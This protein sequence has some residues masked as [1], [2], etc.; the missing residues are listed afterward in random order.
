MRIGTGGFK[1]AKPNWTMAGANLFSW[2][3]RE[4]M[5]AALESVDF[6]VVIE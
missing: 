4:E 6:V 2:E 5:L 3:E 1:A